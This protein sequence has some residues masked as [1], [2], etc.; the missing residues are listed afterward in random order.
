MTQL[1]FSHLVVICHRHTR[2]TTAIITALCSLAKRLKF[3][4]YADSLTLK[5][6]KKSKLIP[7]EG[8]L[9]E[10][11]ALAV[12]IG[13]DGNF[14]SAAQF[15]ITH[16]L[17]ILGINRGTL[18]FLTD[19][20]TLEEITPILRGNYKCENRSLLEVQ[21]VTADAT[22]IKTLVLNDLVLI[23]KDNGHIMPYTVAIDNQ[24]LCCYRA[25][26]LIFA[27]PTGSTARTLSAGGSILEPTINGTLLVPILS[28]NLTSRQMILDSSHTI[29]IETQNRRVLRASII[30]DGQ[31]LG[32][33]YP[34]NKIT[35]KAAKSKLEI[36]HPQNYHYFKL[37][38]NKL[39]WETGHNR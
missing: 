21:F 19:L 27:T 3:K 5:G 13:G 9:F 1:K 29:T 25:D 36:L 17:P 8:V 26:G 28:H 10:K 34:G 16:K 20:Q 6:I 7:A 2:A 38:S 33:L 24:R 32:E 30:G 12:S 15:A 14:L 39:H 35:L 4:L 23:A 31:L 37:L 22:K 18:G 11:N